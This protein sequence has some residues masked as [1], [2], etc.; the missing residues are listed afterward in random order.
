MADRTNPMNHAA[1]GGPGWQPRLGGISAE[2]GTIWG[3]VGINSEYGRLKD[4][5][6]H[7]PGSEIITDKAMQSITCQM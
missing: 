7:R 1:Y 6:L 5:L 4:V 3:N 2:M